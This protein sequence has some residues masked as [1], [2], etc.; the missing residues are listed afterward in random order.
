[1]RITPHR[2]SF[3]FEASESDAETRV[4]PGFAGAGILYTSSLALRRR[5][6]G[7]CPGKRQRV[8]VSPGF[9]P[10]PSFLSLLP[11]ASETNI[12]GRVMR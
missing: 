4:F 10:A 12:R 8:S 5:R 3:G 7:E 2:C 9:W 11:G 1:M 6:A